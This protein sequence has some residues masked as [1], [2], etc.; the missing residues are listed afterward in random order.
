MS[1]MLHRAGL[2]RPSL[3]APAPSVPEAFHAG[4]WSLAPGDE[5]AH[6][7]IHALPNDG[8][9]AIS[10]IEYRI[11]G[12]TWTSSGGTTDFT[13][14]SLTND[15]EYDV[16]LRAVNSV[17]PGA[18]S[19]TKSITPEDTGGAWHPTDLASMP[20]A[21]WDPTVSGSLWQDTG[22]TA[23]AADG[24]PLGRIDDQSTNGNHALQAT[25][26]KRPLFDIISGVPWIVCDGIDDGMT[27]T[28]VKPAM[29][30]AVYYINSP[31]NGLKTLF[32]IAESNFNN[33]VS[34]V[35]ANPTTAWR[36]ADTFNFP[37]S[38]GEIRV[39]GVLTSSLAQGVAQILTITPGTAGSQASEGLG[40]FGLPEFTGRQ[41]NGR[42]G[43]MVLLSALPSGPE[44]DNLLAWLAAPYGIS[45]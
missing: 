8:G 3:A 6:V 25:S 42:M 44:Y 16:D 34:T 43:R 39:D 17:G 33:S 10:D 40:A 28:N 13:L 37:F 5:E 2:L 18:A 20:Y 7:T 35:N 14:T 19:D 27:F 11:D 9:A 22:A 4:D 12:G 32:A 29:V 45:V 21:I 24:D 1:L 30:A 38:T 31:T 15:Q 23:P 41:W 36:N 26:G